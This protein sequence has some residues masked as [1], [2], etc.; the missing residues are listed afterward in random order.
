MPWPCG[1]TVHSVF[2]KQQRRP[3]WLE[4]NKREKGRGQG[5]V[6]EVSLNAHCKDAGFP[7]AL[8]SHCRILH[9]DVSSV[10]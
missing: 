7:F 8:G 2:Q 1:A 10:I 6:V 3:A 4:Q 9:R 5:R